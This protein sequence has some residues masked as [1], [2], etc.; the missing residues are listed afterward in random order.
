M[1][2]E[3]GPKCSG[4]VRSREFIKERVSRNN[5]TFW[6]LKFQWYES[7]CNKARTCNERYTRDC[8]FSF[9]L[10]PERTWVTYPSAQLDC[11][12]NIPCQC[13]K[14]LSV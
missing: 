10:I 2:E 11:S 7:V 3:Y 12:W 5:W 6:D 9:K 1:S 4:L 13:L 14:A 8:V